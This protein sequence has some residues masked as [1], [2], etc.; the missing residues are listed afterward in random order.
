MRNLLGAGEER[1]WYES[2]KTF[3]YKETP[4]GALEMSVHLP[5][6][7]QP[8]AQRP[9]IVFF[10]GGGWQAGTTR[11]FGPPMQHCWSRRLRP[12]N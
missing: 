1:F 8:D 12:W 11:Q 10:F 7:L 9:A 5:H 3:V 2:I 4:Q 6:D